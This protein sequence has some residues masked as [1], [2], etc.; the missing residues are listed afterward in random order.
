MTTEEDQ[1]QIAQIV[2]FGDKNN[3]GMTRKEV[4]TL[5]LDWTGCGSY[6]T[7]EN[8]FEYLVRNGKMPELKKGG[9]VVMAQKQQQRGD[10]LQWSNISGGTVL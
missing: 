9:R 1:R 3:N 7:A 6:K 5:I 8:H 4:V 2:Q 10:K